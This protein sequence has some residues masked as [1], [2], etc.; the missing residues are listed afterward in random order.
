MVWKLCRALPGIC[1]VV[2]LNNMN[3]FPDIPARVRRF[4]DDI[5]SFPDSMMVQKYIT[6]GD[7]YLLGEDAYFGLKA[8]VSAQFGVHPSEVLVVG[9]GKLGFSIVEGKR[10]RPFGDT[11]DID[12]AIISPHLFDRIWTDV[13]DYWRERSFWPEAREFRDYL[14]RGWIRP[15]KLPPEGEFRFRKEWWGFFRQIESQ[16]EYGPYKIRGAIWRS[17]HFLESYQIISIQRI[18]EMTWEVKYEDY[19]Y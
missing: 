4:Q 19:S 18:V 5:L 16:R 14:F 1:R 15:D 3:V 9:S 2:K 10:Y 17:W 11:S 13:F 6:H 7:C 12:I 8:E